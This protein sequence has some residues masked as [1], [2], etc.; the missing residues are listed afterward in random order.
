MYQLSDHTFKNMKSNYPLHK[1]LNQSPAIDRQPLMV[2]AYTP[3]TEAITRMSQHSASCVLVIEK[4]QLV[5]IFT[6]RD[7]VK[8]AA[9]MIELKHLK[10]SQVMT[11][12]PICIS[13]KENVDI[14]SVLSMLRQH[15]IRHLPALDE[16]GQVIGV[17]TPYTIRQVLQPN[18]LLKFKSIDRLMTT[19]VIHAPANLNL[20]QITQLMVNHQISC[21][22]I[23]EENNLSQDIF[24]QGI[25]TERDI[26]QFTA[27]GLNLACIPAK[28]VMSYPLLPIH[29]ED[30]VWTAHQIMQRHH[31]RRLV[32]VD[33]HGK[34][35]GIITQTHLLKAFNPVEMYA[36]IEILQKE[37]DERST[38]LEKT[39]DRLQKEIIERE[40]ELQDRI[41]LQKKLKEQNLHL[42]Q[43]LMQ[44]EVA[45]IAKTTFLENIS[46][47]L[48]TPLH[49]ILGFTQLMKRNPDAISSEYQ[50]YL[51]IIKRNGE[52]LLSL[53]ENLLQVSKVESNSN[54]LNIEKIDLYA[55]LHDIEHLFQNRAKEK[56][57][58][59][60]ITRSAKV[61][62]Y[63]QTDQIK[64]RQVLINLID[65]AI[66]F[67]QSGSVTVQ[68]KMAVNPSQIGFI[69]EKINPIHSLT[70][71]SL[72]FTIEDTGTGIECENIDNIFH[73]CW[74]SY[75][76]EKYKAG[77]GLGL[78]ISRFFVGLMG[79]EISLRNTSKGTICQF[80]IQV[81]LIPVTEEKPNEKI[82]EKPPQIT[83][84][85]IAL[86]A[87]QPCYR[88]LIV[89]E[90]KNDR[91]GL[92]KILSPLGFSLAEASNNIEATKIWEHWEPH[93]IFIDMQISTIDSYK[94][95]KQIK[96]TIK[97]QA[98]TIIM[99]QKDSSLN[100]QQLLNLSDGN[101]WILKPFQP[102]DIFAKINKHLGVRYLYDKI[103]QVKLEKELCQPQPN[104]KNQQN[105]QNNYPSQNILTPDAIN[106]LPA[107]L[108]EE[109][110]QASIRINLQ[111]I[112]KIVDKIRIYHNAE[113]AEALTTLVE[114]FK[115]TKIL[116][117]IQKAR[118]R[119]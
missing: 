28:D 20:L 79:G 36:T 52:H 63:I 6:E 111:D 22:V 31:V 67:T 92:T 97:G 116:S 26:V 44:A 4:K 76:S 96:S 2:S 72:I 21:V 62:Q 3:V 40:K 32:V 5:G 69:P 17:I 57:L 78:P 90:N 71:G 113:L 39:N 107:E 91:Q 81:G 70:H 54:D 84:E 114:D 51:D 46:H 25:I 117:L 16:S 105:P 14:A 49:V 19:K 109:L 75:K 18:D 55:L 59:F 101:D 110:E 98:T 83:G 64:L 13:L 37:V 35:A 68:V 99:I 115:Y 23:R 10:I 119:K 106:S 50:E 100:Q 58:Q 80:N 74:Q 27:L 38:Q 33:R 9:A 89:D 73:N 30:S 45:A 61:P 93:L 42:Q 103:D 7:I 11:K 77:M 60:N 104:Q 47:E 15:K 82:T 102:A 94:F 86:E 8:K 24:P 29:T 41:A 112:F 85:I 1:L 48:R 118:L 66:K 88:I 12:N 34:L 95:I 108:V 56:S 65:N 53:I 43:A 87:N